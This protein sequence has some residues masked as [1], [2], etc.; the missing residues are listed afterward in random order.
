M[1]T[2]LA[3]MF[4]TIGADASGMNAALNATQANLQSRV[5]AMGQL[6]AGIGLSMGLGDI[7]KWSVGLAMTMETTETAMDVIIKDTERTKS[8]LKE[9]NEYSRLTP[10]KPDEIFGAAK[11]LLSAGVPLEEIME[12]IEMLGDLASGAGGKLYEVSYAFMQMH[13]DRKLMAQ[14]DTRFQTQMVNIMGLAEKYGGISSNVYRKMREQG[15]ITLPLVTKWLKQATEAGGIFYQATLK[16]STRTSGLWSTLTG[17]IDELGKA[18]GT[19]LLSPFSGVMLMGIEAT[20]V[21]LAFNDALAGVPAKLLG[22]SMVF[23][24]LFTKVMTANAALAVFN[25]L[26]GPKHAVTWT[27]LIKL[28]LK[29]G[30]IIA[31]ATLALWGLY[32]AMKLIGSLPAISLALGTAGTNFAQ[33]FASLKQAAINLW[34]TFGSLAR[35]AIKSIGID[36][37]GLGSSMDSVAAGLIT[38]IS[39]VF[40]DFGI[41]LELFTSHWRSTWDWLA[42]E[43]QVFLTYIEAGF[44]VLMGDRAKYE[45]LRAQSQEDRK[46]VEAAR[47]TMYTEFD[48][49]E[50]RYK[51]KSEESKKSTGKEKEGAKEAADA[52]K[53]LKEAKRDTFFGPEE[54]WT[55]MLEGE[56]LFTTPF[57]GAAAGRPGRDTT[58]VSYLIRDAWKIPIPGRVPF[59]NRA[60]FE[61]ERKRVESEK[62]MAAAADKLSAAVSKGLVVGVATA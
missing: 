22:L 20:N 29:W 18:M 26:V 15:Q 32:E 11:M 53:K 7:L 13:Q 50:A 10:F 33:M 41:M 44:A 31:G 23:G 3:E 61:A 60:E 42:A 36:F 1:A 45:A 14:S 27:G 35:S 21:V 54:L 28:G 2:K 16:Q 39:G 55:K 43:A 46:N 30:L 37:A 34:G 38:T 5:Q 56:P 59:K 9:L 49:I 17:N 8:L 62:K 47:R 51:K 57:T 6:L 4:V 25:S 52:F 48:K 19:E 58:R 40:R 12:D 24:L